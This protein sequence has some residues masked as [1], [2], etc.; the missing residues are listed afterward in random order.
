VDTPLF[1][2]AAQRGEE[3]TIRAIA[4]AELSDALVQYCNEKLRC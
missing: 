3:G 4:E 1:L 2:E